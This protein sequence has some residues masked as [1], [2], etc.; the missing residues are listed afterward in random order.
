MKTATK[1]RFEVI[2]FIVNTI[3][4]EGREIKIDYLRD[5]VE[6]EFSNRFKDKRVFNLYFDSQVSLL[7]ENYKLV[8]LNKSLIGL[9]DEGIGVYEL[10]NGFYDFLKQKESIRKKQHLSSNMNIAGSIAT[11]LATCLAACTLWLTYSNF[12]IKTNLI[13]LSISCFILGF[14]LRGLAMTLLKYLWKFR[15]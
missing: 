14:V 7:S 11:V 12:Q 8:K 5:I 15:E 1:E 6:K 3:G 9:T 2:S 13:V 4:D 10:K